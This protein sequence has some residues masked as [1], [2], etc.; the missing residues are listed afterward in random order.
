MAFT[1]QSLSLDSLQ[2]QEDLAGRVF[3]HVQGAE[4]W[5]PSR[6]G[7]EGGRRRERRSKVVAHCGRGTMYAGVAQ[8]A[9]LERF[10]VRLV[11]RGDVRRRSAN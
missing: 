11:A 5:S 6:D 10:G 1:G 3:E 4:M 2:P 8:L 9:T 7:L